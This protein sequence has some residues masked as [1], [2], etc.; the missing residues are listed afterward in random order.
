M[1]TFKEMRKPAK[2]GGNKYVISGDRYDMG[3]L[4]RV[5]IKGKEVFS[6][7]LDGEEDISYKGKKYDHYA[8]FLDAIAKDHKVD[9]KSIQVV[10]K[11]D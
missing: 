8:K 7:N 9:P 6:Q 11:D 10:Q 3:M 5:Y 4:I 1:K 2:D